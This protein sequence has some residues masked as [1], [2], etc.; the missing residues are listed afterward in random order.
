[1][2]QLA[3]NDLRWISFLF[4]KQPGQ[5][6]HPVVVEKMLLLQKGQIISLRHEARIQ[7]KV[8]FNFY[9]YIWTCDNNYKSNIQVSPCWVT[10]GDAWF[11]PLESTDVPARPN[12]TT[13]LRWGSSKTRLVINDLC[14]F[15]N[16]VCFGAG[17]K[18]GI[19][20]KVLAVKNQ[21]FSDSDFMF[22]CVIFRSS[23]LIHKMSKLKKNCK[24]TCEVV[25][26][27]WH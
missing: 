27:K 8:F 23:V 15:L 3:T 10:N 24:V 16:I 2:F 11:N 17:R 22:F 6:T 18:R 21:T 20:R 19:Q 12:H 4:L 25:L 7:T 14:F 26:K 1:M 13:D 9:Y 5:K